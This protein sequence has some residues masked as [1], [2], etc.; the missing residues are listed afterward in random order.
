MQAHYSAPGAR[1]SFAMSI[2]VFYNK[3]LF[4]RTKEKNE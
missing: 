4:L 3:Y 2:C 1:E